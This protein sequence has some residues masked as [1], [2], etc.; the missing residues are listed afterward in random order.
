MIFVCIGKPLEPEEMLDTAKEL[1]KDQN[2]QKLS[3]LASKLEIQ[4]EELKMLQGKYSGWQL[5]MSLLLL[6]Q[7]HRKEDHSKQE[8]ITILKK[9]GYQSIALRL[10]PPTIMY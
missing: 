1:A 9:L 5:T 2:Q 3:L 10:N 4:P 7:S 8:L 6:W